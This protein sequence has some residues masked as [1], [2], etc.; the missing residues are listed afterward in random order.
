VQ[1]VTG[2]DVVA[3]ALSAILG[4][5]TVLVVAGMARRL[6]GRGAAL[7]AALFVALAPGHVLHSGFATVDVA[8]T[9]F[10]TLAVCFGVSALDEGAGRRHFVLA[11]AAAGLAAGTKYGAGLA[12]VAPLAAVVS[13][14]GLQVTERLRRGALAVLAAGLAFVLAVPYALLVPDRF[15]EDVGYEL[16]VHPREGHVDIFRDTGDGWSYHLLQNLP[17]ALGIPLLVL[18]VA[19]VAFLLARRRRGDVVLL[20]FALPYFF[21][22][23]LSKVRFLRYTLPLVPVLAIAAAALLERLAA[24]NAR[25][26]LLARPFRVRQGIHSGA[27]LVDRVRG[28]AYS[29]VLDVA[30]HLQKYAPVDGLLVSAETVALLPAEM[31]F[32][33]VGEIGKEGVAAYRFEALAPER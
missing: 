7:L 16:L 17:Y 26:N 14:T 13:A 2:T 27:S 5:G 15:R 28:V 33:P 10:A 21:G 20:A 4:A 12:L 29:P 30:G 19:G 9:F 23:G 24:F 1:T 22:L 25:E 31:R 18:G 3:R 8:A 32:A 6:L 11:G